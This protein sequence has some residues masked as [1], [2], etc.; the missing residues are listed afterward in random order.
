MRRTKLFRLPTLLLAATLLALT[1]SA[2][3]SAA[4]QTRRGGS[5]PISGT[6][7]ATAPGATSAAAPANSRAA[8]LVAEGA[9][10]LARGDEPSAREA[11]EKA[12]RADP[13]NVDA[14]TY[15]G[16]LSDRAGDLKTA[17]KHFAAAA[18]FA[19]FNASARNNY[20]AILIRTGRTQLAAAQFEASLKL[21]RD[22]PNALVNLAQIRFDAGTPEDLRAARELFEHAARVAPDPEVARALVVIALRLGERE[23]AAA[24]Y[25]DYTALVPANDAR[26]ANTSTNAAAAPSVASAASR[27]ELGAALLEAGLSEEAIRELSAAVA[28]EP[29]NADAVIALARAH[30]KRK[31]VP[32][33]GRALEGAVARG[34]DAAAV[35]AALAEVYEAG[36]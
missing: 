17:E 32:A 28:S 4:A 34:L 18:Q 19:P 8:A 9:D 30:L 13:E 35:Y 21:D 24:A 31:D 5:R 10:A 3:A 6:V 26:A 36:G 7:A 25:R 12:L 1:A 2:H 29:S 27:A 20:G 22:Q 14:H 33:A 15:L 23:R 11:F 16:V